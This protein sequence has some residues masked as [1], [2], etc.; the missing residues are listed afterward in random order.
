MNN[1]WKKEYEPLTSI[2]Q[3]WFKDLTNEIQEKKLDEA[4]YEL[5]LKKASGPSEISYEHLKHLGKA[6]RNCIREIFNICLKSGKTSKIWKH[7]NI[8]SIPK[9]ENWKADLNNTRPI[10]L[11]ETARKLFTKIIM[12]RLTTVIKTHNVLKGSNFAGLPG[13]STAEPIQL[14]NNLCKE[15]REKGQ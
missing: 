8:Y 13:E 3:E 11:L 4:M 7:S 15:A 14:L 1:K 6:G 9:H 10:I 5:P 12:N 2:N